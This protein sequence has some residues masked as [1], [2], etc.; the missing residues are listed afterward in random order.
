MHAEKPSPSLSNEH[1]HELWLQAATR[2]N[3]KKRQARQRRML[4]GVAAVALTVVGVGAAVRA[5][6][7]NVQPS[8]LLQRQGEQIPGPRIVTFSDNSTAELEPKTSVRVEHDAINEVRVTMAGGRARFSVTKNKARAFH[9]MTRGVDVRVVGT[10]FVVEDLGDGVLVSVDE[11]TVEVRAGDELRRLTAGQSWRG[12][13]DPAPLTENTP[14][15]DSEP[16]EFESGEEPE[17]KAVRASNKT[18][19]RSAKKRP[20][21]STAL[22]ATTKIDPPTADALFNAGIEARR[23]G[24]AVTAKAA[25]RR[26]LAEFPS[27]ARAGLASFELGRIEMDVNHNFAASLPAIQMALELAPD[28]TFAE[29]ALARLVQLYDAHQ[30]AAACKVAKARYLSRYPRGTYAMSLVSLCQP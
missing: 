12:N 4:L 19:A 20:V 22:P 8:A 16:I 24:H 6:Q 23:T 5:F 13:A 11:G 25:W 17:V 1:V 29:D 30:N 21:A 18:P 10:R 14:S 26:F 2:M 7:R 3:R 15:V 28:A 9:V 27:D